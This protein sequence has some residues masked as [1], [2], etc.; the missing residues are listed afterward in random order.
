MEPEPLQNDQNDQSKKDILE[1]FGTVHM[2]G[3]ADK[4]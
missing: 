4:M 3:E 1:E 2:A